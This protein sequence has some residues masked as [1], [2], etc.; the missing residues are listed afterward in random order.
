MATDHVH[1]QFSAS[2]P[3]IHNNNGNRGISIDDVNYQ[4]WYTESKRTPEPNDENENAGVD[5]DD[6]NLDVN[7]NDD[8]N[9]DDDDKKKQQQGKYMYDGNRC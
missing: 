9:N 6:D 8:G 7:V 2:F 4:E 3:W 5:D 1:D